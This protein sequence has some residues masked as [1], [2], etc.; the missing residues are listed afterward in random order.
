[1]KTGGEYAV[2]QRMH[3]E[4]DLV[5]GLLQIVAGHRAV[6]GTYPAISPPGG[7]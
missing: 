6:R 2:V 4:S 3:L 7:L 5:L 1:L